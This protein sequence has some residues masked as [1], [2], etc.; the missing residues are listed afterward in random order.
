MALRLIYPSSQCVRVHPYWDLVDDFFDYPIRQRRKCQRNKTKSEWRQI[1]NE[2]LQL[3][4]SNF[5]NKTT[6]NNTNVN[7]DKF[8]YNLELSGFNPE[9]IKVKTVGQQVVIEATQED[10]N[11]DDGLKSYSKRQIHKTLTLPENVRPEDVTSALNS[12]GVLRITAPIVSL[13]APED[14]EVEIE[15]TQEN[16]E[17]KQEIANES[18]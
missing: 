17:D 11:E 10:S 14:K 15:I 12:K 18:T 5:S 2:L 13:P 16:N 6:N 4:D 9:N 8:T 1:L 3:N 7:S